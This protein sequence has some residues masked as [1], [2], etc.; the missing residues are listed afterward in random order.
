MQ[1][2]AETRPWATRMMAFALIAALALVFLRAAI[3]APT[4]P[5]AF[6]V[7]DN[8]SI[9]RLFSVRDWLNGQGWFD[10]SNNRVLPPEGISLHW[11]RYVD[12]A[13]PA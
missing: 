8:D 11:S 2:R 4:W 3:V 13:S 12:L 6:A 5:S 10:M 9:M 1:S 7:A